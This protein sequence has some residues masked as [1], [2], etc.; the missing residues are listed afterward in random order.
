MR[1]A[2][3][4]YPGV[5][6]VG[7]ASAPLN[8]PVSLLLR[9]VQSGE[10]RLEFDNESG[11]LRSMLQALNVPVESQVAVFSNT[12]LQS[13]RIDPANPRTISLTTL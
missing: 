8:D 2:G 12:S 4:L 1:A 13:D 5:P 7:Y 10:V 11:Y 9:K 6:I 3:Q